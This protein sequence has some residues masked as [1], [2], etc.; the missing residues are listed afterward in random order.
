M[1]AGLLG[2]VLGLGRSFQSALRAGPA[3]LVKQ[4]RVRNRLQSRRAGSHAWLVR[5][6]EH[7]SR[8]TRKTTTL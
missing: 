6:S 2:R 4:S 7:R 1:D 5:W 3:G 8:G